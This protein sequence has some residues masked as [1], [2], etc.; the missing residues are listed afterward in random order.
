MRNANVHPIL[1]GVV[2]AVSSGVPDSDSCTRACEPPD[3]VDEIDLTP[4]LAA[5][6][7]AVHA[8]KRIGD[9]PRHIEPSC[10]C[11]FDSDE[12]GYFEPSTDPRCA[13]LRD[14]VR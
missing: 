11:D 6:I 13:A 3:P 9:E 1:R 12:R 5:S 8:R 2:N 4:V 7:A 10:E 14:S